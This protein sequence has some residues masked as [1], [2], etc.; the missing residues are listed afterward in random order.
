MLKIEG[1][2]VI[3]T[4]KDVKYYFLP[5]QEKWTNDSKEIKLGDIS[6]NKEDVNM[7]DYQLMDKEYKHHKIIITANL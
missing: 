2:I 4:H 1:W 3:G 5:S 7:D 6:S